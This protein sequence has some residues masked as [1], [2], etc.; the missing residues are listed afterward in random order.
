[1]PPDLMSD[2]AIATVCS[3]VALPR[4]TSRCFSTLPLPLTWKRCYSKVR[5]RSVVP[6]VLSVS[7]AYS[8]ATDLLAVSSPLIT[9]QQRFFFLLFAI[10]WLDDL[11]NACLGVCMT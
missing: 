10:G 7:L 6:F 3:D 2:N 8:V 9:R 5:A 4:R 1:M 11:L